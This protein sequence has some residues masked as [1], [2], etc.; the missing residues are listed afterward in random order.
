MLNQSQLR[1]MCG[2]CNNRPARSAGRSVRGFTKW[3]KY[4]SSCDS[5]AYR[6]E[7][8]KDVKCCECGFVAVDSCQLDLVDG[9]TLCANCNRLHIKESKRQEHDGYEITVDAT[10]D[11]GNITI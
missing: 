2:K 7:K 4:C 10:V 8:T 3:R 9:R 11:L 1:P 5:S 6:R